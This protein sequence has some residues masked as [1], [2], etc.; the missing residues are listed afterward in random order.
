MVRPLSR[1]EDEEE[2]NSDF[3]EQHENRLEQEEDIE[4]DDE[5]EDEDG[6]EAMEIDE[7]GGGKV[8]DP[9]TK[10]KRADREEEDEE[11]SEDSDVDDERPRKR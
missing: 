5:V 1:A 8:E 9:P 4:E 3:M 7:D 6:V 10:R 11:D 2:D